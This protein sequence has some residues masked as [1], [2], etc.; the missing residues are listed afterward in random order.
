MLT[1]PTWLPV[2]G[3]VAPILSPLRLPRRPSCR[4]RPGAPPYPDL[5]FFS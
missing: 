3:A 5:D 1:S 4:C 2:S